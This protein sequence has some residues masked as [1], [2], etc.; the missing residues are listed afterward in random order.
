MKAEVRTRF[1]RITLKIRTVRDVCFTSEYGL[2]WLW[3]QHLAIHVLVCGTAFVEK[4]LEREEVAVVGHGQRAHS[5]LA[6]AFDE[7]SDAALAIE[8]GI[9]GVQVKVNEIRLLFHGSRAVGQETI[10]EKRSRRHVVLKSGCMKSTAASRN[11]GHDFSVNEVTV[12]FPARKQ[13]MFRSCV[14]PMKSGAS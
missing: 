8:Q 6:S 9:A 12:P 13:A 1:L 10:V 5:Q 7:R 11:P 2:D 14:I 4:L 3:C